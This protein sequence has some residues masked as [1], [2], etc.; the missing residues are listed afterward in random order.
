MSALS[1]IQPV[2]DYAAAG[3]PAAKIDLLIA[4]IPNP[5]G[6]QGGT[7]VRPG[8]Q[9]GQKGAFLDEMSPAACA[10]ILVELT[11]LKATLA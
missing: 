7:G 6:G 4:L 1:G 2:N 11:A 5:D 8:G 3:T 9:A 10:Q